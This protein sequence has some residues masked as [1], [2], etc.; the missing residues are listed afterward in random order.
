MYISRIDLDNFGPFSERCIEEVSPCLTVVHGPNEAGK[1]AIRAFIRS[2]LF[3]YTRNGD[4]E[5]DRDLYLYAPLQGGTSAGSITLRTASGKS[6]IVQRKDGRNRGLVSVMGDE[7]GGQELLDRLMG[8]IGKEMYHNI[9]SV[10]LSELQDIRSLNSPQ[11]RDRI[12]SVGLGLSNVSLPDAAKKLDGDLKE[13]RSPRAGRIRTM[14]KDLAEA[15]AELERVRADSGRYKDITDQIA[16][17]EEKITRVTAQLDDVRSRRER[18]KQLIDLR[19]H[20]DRK[21]ALEQQLTVLP[22]IPGFIDSAEARYDNLLSRFEEL[23]EAMREGDA[24]Q[25]ART[26]EAKNVAVLDA[27]I[28]NYDAARRLLSEVEHY[29]KAVE[30]LPAV[31]QDLHEEETKLRRDL[32]LIGPEWD[33]QRLLEFKATT[34]IRAGLESAGASLTQAKEQ[35]RT[36]EEELR[37]SEYAH[38]LAA[39]AHRRPGAAR[40]AL[41]D[42]PSESSATLEQQRDRLLRLRSA[43][44]VRADAQREMREVEVR[45]AEGLAQAQPEAIGGIIAGSLWT[46]IAIILLGLSAVGWGIFMRELSGAI[47]GVIATAA[48][49]ILLIR[50]R[51]SGKA[52]RIVIRRP[53]IKDSTDII[54]EQRDELRAQVK[55]VTEE[56]TELAGELGLPE[57][58]SVREIEEH[59]GK[60]DRSLDLCR[61]YES[62]TSEMSAAAT[63]LKEA[64]DH[65]QEARQARDEAHAAVKDALAHWQHALESVG[66]KSSL[67]PAQAAEVFANIRALKNQQSNV[68]SLRTRVQRINDTIDDVEERLAAVLKAAGMAGFNRLEGIP[69]LEDLSRRF[70]EHQLAVERSDRLAKELEEWVRDRATLERRQSKVQADIKSLMAPAQTTDEA[71]FRAIAAKVDMRRDVERQLTELHLNHP[72]LINEEGA[73]YREALARKRDDEMK[74]KLERFE[75]EVA[76]FEEQV[77]GLHRE[78]GDLQRQKTEFEESNAV[79]VLHQKINQLEES[80]REDANRW[81]VLTIA[82]TLLDRT[83][84]E[85][86]RERQ[87]ALLQAASRYFTSMTLGRY[88]QVRS[89]LGEERFEVIEGRNTVKTVTDLSRGTAEQL[90]L[91]MRF[92][93]IE[94]YSRIAEP[95]PVIMD[96]VLV[97]FDPE[98]ARAACASIMQLSSRFQVIVLTCHPQTVEY[99]RDLTPP[100]ADGLPLSV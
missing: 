60:L 54:E 14:E 9:F 40:Q 74:A 2:V 38:G 93:L 76:R 1:S 92:A 83:R 53:R 30:D 6:Y 22:D 29:R 39:D 55:A 44:A 61:R 16:E 28:Y 85:F 41:G 81:A 91:S 42:A 97:N 8:H 67:A 89:V 96:D 37:Q 45:L 70:H 95:M 82:R 58:P 59:A 20:W 80:L 69:A 98:R 84:D 72:L 56:I 63:R 46:G 26:T 13:L 65:L 77:A 17:L 25:E 94:E 36:A 23:E 7:A 35:A 47:P 100:G 43:V 19:Q 24:K 51:L 73:P 10:S 50:A 99:F 78:Q 49:L 48:G 88:S 21:Q 12:Y 5:K 31:E 27:F 71:E 79:V 33:E 68:T 62:L 4:G 15:R 66:L 52:M 11:I 34:D 18:Q 57:S 87:P 3:G 64:E 32:E 90:Y 75:D 86:Q